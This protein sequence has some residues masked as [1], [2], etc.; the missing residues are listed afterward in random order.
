[1]DMKRIITVIVSGVVLLLFTMSCNKQNESATHLVKL[2]T[3]LN[4]APDKEL[5]NGTVLT[6]C[7]YAEGDS[8]FTYII[9]V[10][11]NRYDKLETDSIKNNFA[12]T[13]KSAGM[14]KIVNLLHQANVGLKYN[15]EL[16]EKQVAIEFSRAEIADI[17]GQTLK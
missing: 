13:V 2:A 4:N 11:D 17:A 12:K 7:E 6:G 10:S 5:G 9:K 16:P 3:E 14:A 1:M 15:L 8:M